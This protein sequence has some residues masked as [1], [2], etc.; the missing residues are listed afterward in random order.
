MYLRKYIK[1]LVGLDNMKYHNAAS[2]LYRQ[3]QAPIIV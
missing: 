1:L 2:L 3:G